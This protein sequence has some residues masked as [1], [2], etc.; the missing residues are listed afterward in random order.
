MAPADFSRPAVTGQTSDSRSFQHAG[1][2]LAQPVAM[3]YHATHPGGHSLRPRSLPAAAMACCYRCC[4]DPRAVVFACTGFNCCSTG[5]LVSTGPS[6]AAALQAGGSSSVT[7]LMLVSLLS[8][9]A[10]STSANKPAAA[11]A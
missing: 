4:A 9:T 3:R 7:P 6:L 1:L 10:S 5:G 8:T 2:P 11:S